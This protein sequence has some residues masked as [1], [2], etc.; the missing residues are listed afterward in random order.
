[1]IIAV[2]FKG[3]LSGG[4][5]RAPRCRLAAPPRNGGTT[6]QRWMK[7]VTVGGLEVHPPPRHPQMSFSTPRDAGSF[8]A[9]GGSTL[10]RPQTE[11]RGR[12]IRT[13]YRP[14]GPNRWTVRTYCRCLFVDKEDN[15]MT[16][17]EFW[18]LAASQ[19]FMPELLAWC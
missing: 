7:Q 16:R 13:S 12:N 4:S 18:L 19:A 10:I 15:T 14:Y 3:S 5:P 2:H 6:R 1:M 11:T 17:T 9:D 8:P